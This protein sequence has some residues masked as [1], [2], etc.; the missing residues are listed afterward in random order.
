MACLPCDDYE[1]MRNLALRS[2]WYEDDD[3][4]PCF[5]DRVVATYAWDDSKVFEGELFE[6]TTTF[7]ADGWWDVT[8]WLVDDDG[9]C[10]ECDSTGI[11]LTRA[12]EDGACDG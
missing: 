3:R 4:R 10:W 9:D 7:R 6:V 8:V 2:L 1:T 5:G 11:G 12:R